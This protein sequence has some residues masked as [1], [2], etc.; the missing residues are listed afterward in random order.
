MQNI[1]DHL[2]KPLQRIPDSESAANYENS[3]L[4]DE[5]GDKLQPE[6]SLSDGLKPAKGRKRN[7]INQADSIYELIYSYALPK[8]KEYLQ[9]KSER[10]MTNTNKARPDTLWK[11]ILRDVREFYRILFRKRF[12]YLD[13]KDF[14]GATN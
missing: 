4:S 12:H 11:K 13:F 5:Q 8:W 9:F 2:Q 7:L 3:D 10:G 6:N 1:K 14:K